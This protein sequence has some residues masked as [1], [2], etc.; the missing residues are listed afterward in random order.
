MV[1]Q[2]EERL[3]K[4]ILTPTGGFLNSYTHSLNPYEGCAFGGETARGPGCPYCYVRELPVAK[5]AGRPWGS[6]VRAKTNAAELIDIDIA[7]FTR[8]HPNR[9]LR[10]FM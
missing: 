8:K 1:W 2:Y 10:I 5:F 6:W 9:R 3:A 7:R 4:S